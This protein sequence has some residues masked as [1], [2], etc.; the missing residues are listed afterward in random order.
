LEFERPFCAGDERMAKKY[1][2]TQP[3]VMMLAMVLILSLPATA[4]EIRSEVSVRGTGFFTK[5]SA[6][7]G[8]LQKSTDTG[9]VLAGYRYHINRWLSAEAVY[10][11]NRNSQLF[12]TPTGYGRVQADVHQ[13][14]GGFVISLPAPRRFGFSPYM[15]AEGGALVFNPTNNFYG[16]IPGAQRQAVGTF[17][18]GGGADF[19]IPM[20]RHVDFRLEYRGLVYD[21]PDFG[22]GRLNTNTITHTAEPSAGLVF[23][24]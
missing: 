21:A 1:N 4:Q 7:Q 22:L 9:G 11:W 14:T 24:F 17:V 23:K 6:G 8:N 5:D 2:A 19:P 10:G 15:L 13:A 12:S 20:V 16:T 18:Y 3:T